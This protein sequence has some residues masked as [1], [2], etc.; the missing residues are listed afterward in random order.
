MTTIVPAYNLQ[1]GDRIVI[2]GQAHT[3]AKVGPHG[4]LIPVYVV[5]APDIPSLL[6]PTASVQLIARNGHNL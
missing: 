6:A 4:T 3:V 2:D 5:G 1:P